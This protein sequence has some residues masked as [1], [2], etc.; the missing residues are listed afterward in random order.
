MPRHQT[1]HKEVKHKVK[2]LRKHQNV[3]K[4]VIGP[5]NNCR[6][7]YKPGKILIKQETDNGFKVFAYDGSGIFTL[8]VYVEPIT[9][10][11]IVREYIEKQFS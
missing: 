1:L 4:V 7:R 9:A 11:N 6:H 10:R 2:K 3:K 8:Y 5:F